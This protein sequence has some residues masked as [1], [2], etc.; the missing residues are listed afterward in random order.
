MVTFKH[1]TGYAYN[2]KRCRC[3]QCL[4]WYRKRENDRREPE[5]RLEAWDETDVEF[6][7]NV[8]R[9][10]LTSTNKGIKDAES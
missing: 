2:D 7:W 8:Y 6:F 1:G 4:H 3:P 9:R 5:A 10:R